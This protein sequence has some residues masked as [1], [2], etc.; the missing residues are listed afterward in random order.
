MRQSAKFIVKPCAYCGVTFQVQ[1]P[2]KF[3]Q[4]FCGFRCGV[5]NRTATGPVSYLLRRREL[6]AMRG[7]SKQSRWPAERWLDVGDIANRF[8]RYVSPEPNTGC[9]LWIG[10]TGYAGYGMFHVWPDTFRANRF[11]WSMANRAP[12]PDGLI[13]LHKCDTPSCVNPDHLTVGT[14]A[15]NAEDMRRK[16]RLGRRLKH[17]RLVGVHR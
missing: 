2:S 16:G 11:A 17:G 13:I 15:D 8:D 14:H 3:G 5:A 10:G 12:I 4:R 9:H 6:W 1:S 7:G